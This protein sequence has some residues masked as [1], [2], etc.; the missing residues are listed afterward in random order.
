MGSQSSMGLMLFVLTVFLSFVQT[1]KVKSLCYDEGKGSKACEDNDSW[2]NIGAAFHGYDMVRG[3]PTSSGP[4]PGYRGVIFDE[5]YERSGPVR[6]DNT[7]VRQNERCNTQINSVTISSGEEYQESIFN[8]KGSGYG[9]KIGSD[10]DVGANIGGSLGTDLSS[11]T[12]P[13]GSLPL[14]GITKGLGVLGT[15][16]AFAAP[17]T[18]GTSLLPA[19]AVPIVTGLTSGLFDLP[20][21]GI[22]FPGFNAGGDAGLQVNT[23][24]PPLLQAAS[25]NSETMSNKIVRLESN[26]FSLTKSVAKCFLYTVKIQTIQHPVLKQQFIR[27]VKVLS[28][29]LEENAGSL[30]SSDC[31]REFFNNY[32]THYLSV[33]KFGSK[34]TLEKMFDNEESKDISNHEK[35]TCSKR[36]MQAS[37]FGLFGGDKGKNMCRGD[38]I[39]SRKLQQ[40]RIEKERFSTIGSR[41]GNSLTEW[42]SQIDRPEIIEK[43]ILPLSNLFTHWFMDIDDLRNVN[44]TRIKPWLEDQILSYCAI[45]RGEGRC[46][47]VVRRPVCTLTSCQQQMCGYWTGPID[48]SFLPHGDGILFPPKGNNNIGKRLSFDHGCLVLTKEINICKSGW[49]EFN[50]HC[51]KLIDNGGRHYDRRSTCMGHCSQEGG[52]LTSIHSREENDFVTSLL[53]RPRGKYS[54]KYAWIGAD[55][56]GSGSRGP[57]KWQDGTPW[58]FSMWRSNEP[59]GGDNCVGLGWEKNTPHLWWDG[60]CAWSGHKLYDCICKI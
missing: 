24:I 54:S 16:G 59:D 5:A 47:R 46:N 41:P 60:Y 10:V 34:M 49:S 18:A 29:C 3:D 52:Q 42:A 51:Y 35:E 6:F 21:P 25:S 43:Q 30:R 13:S 31:S 8:R 26:L 53:G 45:F 36:N 56:V 14:S 37:L 11:G 44:Y 50:G 4:D 57:F 48:S 23:K 12:T 32:G 20:I 9:I 58:D 38:G 40:H 39:N 33:A 19:A 2:Q 1:I 27:S 55:N 15:A 28:S 22:P 17:A 7:N